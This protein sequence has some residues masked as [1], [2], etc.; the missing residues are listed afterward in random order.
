M[1]LF[2][3]ECLCHLS[4]ANVQKGMNGY[5]YLKVQAASRLFEGWLGGLGWEVTGCWLLP[6]SQA[7]FG[8][9]SRQPASLRVPGRPVHHAAL[10]EQEVCWDHR[11]H[12]KQQL[13][14]C[15]ICRMRHAERHQA[16]LVCH[17]R[18][19][20]P[21][22]VSKSHN[23]GL[24]SCRD[25]GLYIASIL[26]LQLKGNSV[27]HTS[28]VVHAGSEHIALYAISDGKLTP[29]KASV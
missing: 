6:T 19:K 24:E 14:A 23:L 10:Q 4:S 8:V 22:T 11:H 25:T 29:Q 26:G 28:A 20:V 17:D 15:I 18:C 3:I 2:T 9:T 16:K 12:Q 7:S 21:G 27:Y 5:I 13:L 1:L